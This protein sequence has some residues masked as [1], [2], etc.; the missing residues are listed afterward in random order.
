MVYGIFKKSTMFRLG[1]SCET[2]EYFMVYG[3]YFS[4]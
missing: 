4:V 3:N 1:E 2:F